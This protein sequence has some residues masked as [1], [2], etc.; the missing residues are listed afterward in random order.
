MNVLRGTIAEYEKQH[1]AIRDAAVHDGEL[2]ALP[3]RLQREGDLAV[4]APA[5][6]QRALH[7]RAVAAALTARIKPLRPG[8]EWASQRR[9][10]TPLVTLMNFSG[11]RAA[12]SGNRSVRTSSLC[13]AAT[14]LTRRLAMTARL[15]AG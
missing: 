2:H 13:S 14:P 11:Q 15:A 12:K 6:G 8:F 7:A 1:G 3:D 9:G 5:D 10:V 4:G